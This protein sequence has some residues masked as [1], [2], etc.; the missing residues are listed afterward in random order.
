MKEERTLAQLCF[1]ILTNEILPRDKKYDK[2]LPAR[3][4]GMLAG[5]EYDKKLTRRETRE[6][7]ELWY[8]K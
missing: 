4:A 7:L 8:N 3:L 5:L 1:V 2:V 6:Y